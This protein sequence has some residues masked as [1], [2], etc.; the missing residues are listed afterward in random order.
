MRN[1]Y[2]LQMKCLI[3]A[4]ALVSFLGNSQFSFSQDEMKTAKIQLRFFEKDSVKM[5]EAKVNNMKADQIGDPVANIEVKFYVERTFSLLPFGGRFT[6][7]DD[8]GLVEVE[9]PKNLPGDSAGFV[10][11]IA[12]I[13][14]SEEYK[15]TETS[16]I[17]K[18]GVPTH[19]KDATLKRSIWA[20]AA[21]APIPLL[22][23]VN[24]MIFVVWILMFYIVYR[25]YRVSKM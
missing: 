21:N 18:W 19:L 17:L 2:S 16:Q 7:T 10:H 6:S 4:I 22:I 8:S 23:L 5:V 14:E 25:L 24:S 3:L 9:F 1:L 12:K 20:A 13:T 15:D 11:V